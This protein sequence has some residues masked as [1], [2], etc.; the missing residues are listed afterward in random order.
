MNKH[1]FKIVHEIVEKQPW[2][3][4]VV[5]A[6][7]SL[8]FE[9][10]KDS[11]TLRVIK[12]LLE[13]FT[14]ISELQYNSYI[15]EIAQHISQLPDFIAEKT[16]VSAMGVGPDPDSS[17]EILYRLRIA[18]EKLKIRNVRFSNRCD[19]VQKKINGNEKVVVFIV[20]E[21]IGS[22]QTVRGR[23][24]LLKSCESIVDIGVVVICSTVHALQS[25]HDEGIDVYAL[26]KI[27][28]GLSGQYTDIESQRRKDLVKLV[29][30]KL[31]NEFNGRAMPSLGYNQA[32][33]L[34]SRENGNTP[35][36]VFPVFWWP[37][38]ANESERKTLL[39]RAM[40]DA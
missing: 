21:F 1:E 8:L 27:S 29:E 40:C 19:H 26:L 5:D 6:L 12:D 10:C 25:L 9:D 22:G 11:T 39:I 37:F 17:Q 34:Y 35:N 15:D 13:G 14:R 31:S 36:S 32:E 7:R 4:D 30:A 33:A 28:K 23:V 2:I 24:K 16:I 18:F 20:D 38:Y 3:A